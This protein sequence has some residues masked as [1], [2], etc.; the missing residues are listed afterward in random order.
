MDWPS[1]TNATKMATPSQR[2]STTR[3]AANVLSIGD[4][5]KDCGLWPQATCPRDCGCTKG[6]AQ[7]VFQCPKG[8]SLR[9]L[10]WIKFIHWGT[11]N[12]ATPGLMSELTQCIANWR[13]NTSPMPSGL[14]LPPSLK[15]AVE[16]QSNVAWHQEWMGFLSPLWEK[17]QSAHLLSI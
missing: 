11:Q 2:R 9:D 6:T 15:A 1:F 3:L 7:H 10:L 5:V 13:S 12:N 4:I 8:D 16:D 14:R 17:A